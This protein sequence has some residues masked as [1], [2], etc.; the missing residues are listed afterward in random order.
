MKAREVGSLREQ[1]LLENRSALAEAAV[2]LREALR[3]RRQAARARQRRLGDRRNG[4][5]RR[6]PRAPD[7]IWP[8]RPAVDLTEDSAILTAIANDVGVEEIF[9]RQVIAY[10]APA[11]RCSR[12]RPAA[13]RAT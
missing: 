3:R 5:G 13:T 6:L 1:T 7:L 2:A 9:Q 11:T 8:A 10:G 12:S 4:R